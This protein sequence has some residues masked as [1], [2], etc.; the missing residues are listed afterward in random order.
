MSFYL[1]SHDIYH[2]G[3]NLNILNEDISVTNLNN[4]NEFAFMEPQNTHCFSCT[5]AIW[6]QLDSFSCEILSRHGSWRV[7][8]STF[9]ALEWL[10]VCETTQPLRYYILI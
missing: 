5:V 7:Q 3:R 1:G 9:Y 10:A 8:T 6:Q 2:G 4:Y